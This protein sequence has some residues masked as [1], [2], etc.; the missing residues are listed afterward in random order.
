MS[1]DEKTGTYT[2]NSAKPMPP[3]ISP[4]RSVMDRRSM[5]RVL[6]LVQARQV[7]PALAAELLRMPSRSW[8]GVATF[9][10]ILTLAA[11]MS[12]AA[13]LP[14]EHAASWPSPIDP[15]GTIEEHR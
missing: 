15:P 10:A 6:R 14:S 4:P 12:A 8:P 9:L 7:S 2:F 11:L 13:L 5:E 3:P 1:D